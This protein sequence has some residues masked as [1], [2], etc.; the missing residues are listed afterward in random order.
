MLTWFLLAM[1]KLRYKWTFK[2]LE[3]LNAQTLKKS[4]GTLFLSN[5]SAAVIDPVILATSQLFSLAVRPLVIDYMFEKPLFNRFLR[6]AK[7][8]PIPDLTAGYDLAKMQEIE[9]TTQSIICD[10][11]KGDNFL[12]YPA[13]CLKFTGIEEVGGASLTHRILQDAPESNVVLVR[14]KGL[15]GS[16]FSRAQTGKVPDVT[17]T[18]VRGALHILKNGFFFL[19][20]RHIIFEFTPAPPDFPYTGSRRQINRYLSDW[21]NAPDT[22]PPQRHA[23]IV[24]AARGDSLVLVSY[25]FWKD[26]YPS[27]HTS[28]QDQPYSPLIEIPEQ[29]RETIAHKLTSM[30][31][32][33]IEPI[34]LNLDLSQDL[35]LDSL[36]KVNLALFLSKTY[37]I[38]KLDINQLTSV[39][40]TME[41]VTQRCKEDR[42]NVESIPS[43]I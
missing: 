18:F 34:A 27:I 23:R 24:P 13:G 6:I 14:V 31:I 35:G 10:I 17:A 29:I 12:V 33:P 42:E 5:H 7:S 28:P 25:A 1:F 21:F 20:R 40:R 37:G 15:W 9:E 32:P 39:G 4:G 30:T 11:K 26:D 19:P 38:E 43:R 22:L 3:N 36:D 8:L 41:L 2:G 16:S